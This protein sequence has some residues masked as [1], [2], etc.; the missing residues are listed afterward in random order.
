M[1]PTFI[2]ALLHPVTSEC[3]YV[4]KTV[5]P[6]IRLTAHNS[7]AKKSP[8]R[9]ANWIKSLLP[10]KPKMIILEEIPAG[11]DWVEA[12]QFWIAY[13]KS[14]SCDL[15]NHTIGG[16]GTIGWKSYPETK[17]KISIALTG[18]TRSPEVVE[19]MRIRA[20]N[21]SDET[22]ER[23]QI[24]NAGRKQKPETIELI[25]IASTGRK[26]KPETLIK[27]SSWI[28]PK[29]LG[30]KISKATK[31]R[32]VGKEGRDNMSKAAKN[33]PPAS[34]ESRLKM[35]LSKLG[36]LKSEE[37]RAKMR[38]PKSPETIA[39][40]KIAQQAR[41]V[42]QRKEREMKALVEFPIENISIEDADL[43]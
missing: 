20:T 40:M 4:G 31:G 10:L 42:R 8:T 38:K 7:L 39:N 28:R 12:E 16:E 3:R 15:T 34:K 27:M 19:A 21:I 14:L 2:Y 25:R 26:H 17:L 9:S 29:E 35:S 32:K 5:N 1:R 37:T 22:R 6:R 43:Y 41:V 18:L 23:M 33:K 24:A 36:K 30:E 13:I 11:K